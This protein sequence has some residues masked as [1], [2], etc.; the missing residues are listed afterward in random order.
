MT[1]L[2]DLFFA[3]L[4]IPFIISHNEQ[5]KIPTSEKCLAFL[6]GSDKIDDHFNDKVSVYLRETMQVRYSRLREST[7][8]IVLTCKFTQ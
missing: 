8:C 5:Q 6:L 4:P 3:V 1:S 2:S 7:P